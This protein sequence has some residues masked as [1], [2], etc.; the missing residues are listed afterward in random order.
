MLAGGRLSAGSVAEGDELR[1]R[2]SGGEERGAARARQR[3]RGAAAGDRGSVQAG[4]GWRAAA[5]ICRARR[6]SSN[7]ETPRTAA[8]RGYPT[9]ST[10]RGARRSILRPPGL[11]GNGRFGGPIGHHSDHVHLSITNPRTMLAAI[12][13]AQSMGLHVG[14]NP[15][16]DH[17]GVHAHGSFHYQNFPGKYGGKSL[18]KKR[19]TCPATR[20]RWPPSTAGR[21]ATCDEGQPQ[22]GQLVRA[23]SP[24]PQSLGGQRPDVPALAG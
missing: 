18:G 8:P 13:Q 14:E 17:V 10:A 15:Y 2:F 5:S 16:L 4:T 12:R 6:A 1:C 20:K 21:P 24:L 23:V 22:H 9:A 19:S 11:L 7:C 3:P